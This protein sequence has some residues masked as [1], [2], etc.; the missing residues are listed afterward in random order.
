MAF[1][2]SIKGWILGAAALV[3][4][5]F[6]WLAGIR[7]DARREGRE[8]AQIEH[9]RAAHE[10]RERMDKASVPDSRSD[11]VDGLRDDRF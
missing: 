2:T 7:R 1:L 11:L 3:V 5:A 4:A 6:F 10:A 8:Q 9:E